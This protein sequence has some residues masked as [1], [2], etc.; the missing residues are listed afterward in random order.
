MDLGQTWHTGPYAERA[1]DLLS[2]HRDAVRALFDFYD[3]E[4]AQARGS[5]PGWVITHGE[6]F[7][8]NLLR[9]AD[10]R[11]KLVD[12]DSL[13]IAPRE[14]D[15][16]ELP[17]DGPAWVAYR[18]VLQAPIEERLLQLYR[19]WYDLAETSVYCLALSLASYGRPERHDRV[20]QLPVL[21]PDLRTLA[22]CRHL[23]ALI[24]VGF[25]AA[26]TIRAAYVRRPTETESDG[27]VRGWSRTG[28]SRSRVR[29]RRESG[30]CPRRRSR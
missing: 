8:P 4:A 23:R 26:L 19:A 20:G 27:P 24:G 16:W 9:C 21:S 12:W 18:E 2:A 25:V 11:F 7:G 13:L 17:R 5:S 10:G 28:R 14:R 15:L 1:R 30:D 29:R 3:T 22:R 6:P